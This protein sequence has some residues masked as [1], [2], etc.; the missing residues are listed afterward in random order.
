MILTCPACKTRYVV[1]DSAVG[2]SGR[3]VR[4]AS[5]K[6]GWF[7]E[8]PPVE[9]EEEAAAFES[10]TNAA[11]PSQPEEHLA[12]P[13]F[14]ARSPA[15]V[16]PP[17]SVT[18]EPAYDAAPDP[19]EPSLPP[20]RTRK[21]LWVAIVIA[22]LALAAAAFVYLGGNR[23]IPIA[24]AGTTALELEYSGKP[25]RRMMESGNELLTVSGRVVNPT[26]EPQKVPQILAELR[27]AQG[28]VVY[29]WAISA[30]V[31]RLQPG[32][33]A[34]FNSAEV[35]VPQSARELKLRFG[36]IS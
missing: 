7:Q 5:C 10:G 32:Q 24:R 15:P 1:P 29:D 17:P 25:E 4:C 18:E 33:R 28:R 30:P 21:W 26:D 27:D 22:L 23:A 11:A 35:D 14:E 2:P 6:H 9:E 8:P 19:T 20:H 12:R 3:Q 16:T 34:T 13:A 36:A 31:P